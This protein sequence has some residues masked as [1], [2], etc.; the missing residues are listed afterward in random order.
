MR[1]EIS[2]TRERSTARPPALRKI[3]QWPPTNWNHQ[4]EPSR[5]QRF[6]IG[7]GGGTFRSRATAKCR[8]RDAS[9]GAHTPRR[10]SLPRDC[11]VNRPRACNE[12]GTVDLQM[13]ATE[14]WSDYSTA[15]SIRMGSP[16]D[17]LRGVSSKYLRCVQPPFSALRACQGVPDCADD[18]P[19]ASRICC[20]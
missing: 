15:S 1:G 2:G 5:L 16:C 8:L 11:K 3:S 14:N 4:R 20:V 13:R 19:A 17:S 6:C 18:R 9:P 12:P 10:L 7:A